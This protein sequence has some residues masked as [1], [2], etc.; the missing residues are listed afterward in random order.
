MKLC[1]T[2]T[3]GSKVFRLDI[4][5]VSETI[6]EP[7]WSAEEKKLRT[8]AIMSFCLINYLHYFHV[9]GKLK[10]KRLTNGNKF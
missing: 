1:T 6:S 7:L 5:G 9:K 10:R 8:T 2:C 3:L 4:S